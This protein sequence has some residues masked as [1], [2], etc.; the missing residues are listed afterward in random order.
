MEVYIE[1]TVLDQLNIDFI[2]EEL[3][4]GQLK[5]KD[6]L[7][8]YDGIIFY[9]DF[10]FD[11]T[12]FQNYKIE[13]LLFTKIIEKNSPKSI[14]FEAF[15]NTVKFKQTI[16]I[17]SK[18][19]FKHRDLVESKGGLYFT[20]ADYVTKIESILSHFH[21]RI[22]LSER[23]M[24]WHKIF[25]NNSLKLNEIIINDNYL[26][27]SL[28]NIDT[29]LKPLVNAVKKQNIIERI[30]FF[31]DYLNKSNFEKDKKEMELRTT[32]KSCVE[33]I[34]NNFNN[35]S[36]HDRVL[37]TNFLM[38]DCPIG[39]NQVH[40]VSNSVITIDTIFDKF[41]YNRRRRHYNIIENL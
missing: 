19:N 21:K 29:Y 31:T 4:L 28:S 22:D 41:T 33:I 8:Y 34:H 32:L 26:L 9:T 23:F 37:Y 17:E 1:K 25:T 24:G 18:E 6:I 27:D 11:A 10:A 15:I 20:Y 38:I 35:F 3:S 39:F 2:K 12:Q 7:Y 5:L 13:N 40:R 30:M 14:P 16:A 36:S